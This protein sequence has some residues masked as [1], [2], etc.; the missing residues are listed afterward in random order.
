MTRKSFLILA[1][2]APLAAQ[3]FLQMS[4]PQFGM[5][6]KDTGFAHETVNFEFAIGT[7]NRLKPAFVVV[8]GDLI[9]KAGDAAQAAEYKRIAA[10]LDPAIKLY[11]VAG[12]HDVGNE[13]TPES[14]ALYRER[15]GPDYYSFRVGD[16]AGFVLNSSLLK[17]PDK[18]K[19]EAAKMES[20]LRAELAKARQQGV[21]NLIVFQ[22]IS[23]FLK[24]ADEPD[25]YFNI[26]KETRRRYLDL[27]HE[28]G[29]R[30]VFAGHYHRNAE[31]KDGDL[32]MIT[33]G[34]VGMPLED[35]KSGVRI[36][37]VTR[38]G[39]RHKYFDFGE[40]P[41]ALGIKAAQE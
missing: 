8:T 16:I 40:L 27:L 38:E 39:I 2:A 25:Q 17:A 11:N 37:N 33:T 18:V 24:D 1:L 13:P 19:D 36:V 12:N 34:P 20:W 26:P 28:F 5:Y 9:N 41:E 7:A 30:Y 3:N 10:R 32:D 14:L 29:V 15:F 35:A 22:H 21:R 4:D 31:G 6:A 23:F